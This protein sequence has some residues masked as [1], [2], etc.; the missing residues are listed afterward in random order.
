MR[1]S[2]GQLLGVKHTGEIGVDR[3]GLPNLIDCLASF[4]LVA[5][6]HLYS[7]KV[8]QAISALRQ[9]LPSLS[10]IQHLLVK[11]TEL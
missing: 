11:L 10:P 5:A 7:I 1:T 2:L 4:V 6:I 9:K 8:F 3:D